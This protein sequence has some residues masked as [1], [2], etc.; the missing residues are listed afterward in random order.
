[1]GYRGMRKKRYD[2]ISREAAA[3]AAAAKESSKRGNTTIRKAQ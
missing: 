1:V 3:A 2:M